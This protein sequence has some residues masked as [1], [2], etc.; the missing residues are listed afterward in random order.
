MSEKKAIRYLS[1]AVK[2][3]KLTSGFDDCEKAIRKGKRG[4]LILAAD[5]GQNTIRRAETLSKTDRMRLFPCEY[6]KSELSSAIG[7]GSPVSLILVSD[8]GLAEAFAAA[9]AT[10]QEERI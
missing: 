6:N 1:L 2:A 7:R 8:E 3:G 5:A 10:E 4:L 9:Y